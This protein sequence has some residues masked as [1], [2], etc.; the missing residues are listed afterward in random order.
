MSMYRINA[1]IVSPLQ[2]GVR[3]K[4]SQRDRDGRTPNAMAGAVWQRDLFTSVCQGQLAR[5]LLVTA[6]KLSKAVKTVILVFLCEN[7]LV[8]KSLSPSLFLLLLSL[9]ALFPSLLMQVCN[10]VSASYLTSSCAPAD[11]QQ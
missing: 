11:P 2:A 3:V 6:P 9:P 7:M 4:D 1:G 5:Q 10:E 8:A